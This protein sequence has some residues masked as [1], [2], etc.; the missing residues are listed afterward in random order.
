MVLKHYTKT[1]PEMSSVS[2]PT[3]KCSDI[4]MS[5]GGSVLVPFAPVVQNEQE[6]R[7]F[8]VHW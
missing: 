5:G 1:L 7:P 8:H 3:V 6:E 2:K 4:N